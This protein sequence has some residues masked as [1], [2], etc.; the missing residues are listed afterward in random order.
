MVWCVQT[1]THGV[2]LWLVNSDQGYS[3]ASWGVFR[4]FVVSIV[5]FLAPG[6]EKVVCMWPSHQLKASLD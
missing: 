1:E 4:S 3:F 6:A 5:A 2:R